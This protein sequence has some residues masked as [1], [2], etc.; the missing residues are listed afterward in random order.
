[1]QNN[2]MHPVKKKK[3]KSTKKISLIVQLK[4]KKVMTGK[5]K[6]NRK[7]LIVCFRALKP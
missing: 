7:M 4:W 6:K 3:K 2:H 5:R 1:M